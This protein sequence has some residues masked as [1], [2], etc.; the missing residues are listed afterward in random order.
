MMQQRFPWVQLMQLGI[1]T[2]NIAPRE[3]WNCTLRE[4]IF[5]REPQSLVRAQL[6]ELMKEWPD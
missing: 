5:M 1:G 6:T 3:F 2:Y 4:L